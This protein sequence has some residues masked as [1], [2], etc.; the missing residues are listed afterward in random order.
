MTEAEV[1]DQIAQGLVYGEYSLLLG[2]GAS[3]GAVGGNGRALPTGAGL[4]DALIEQFN[5]DTGGETL[6]LSQVYDYLQQVGLVGQA[7]TFL[8]DW[9]VD[10][11]P[12][13]QHLLAE[14]NWK[15]IWTLNIDD[16]IEKAFRETGRS[17]ESLTWNQR[18]SDRISPSSQ[19]IIH[20]HGLAG[21]LPADDTKNDALVFS[22]SD[23]AREVANP[24]TWHKVFFD[25]F[26]GDSFL[27][28]G[29]QLTQEIDLID[30]LNPGNA[31]RMTTGFPSVV[32]VPE[33][34]QI[35]RTQ[36][37]ASGFT[38][39]E[40]DGERFINRLI[41]HFRAIISE[42][43]SVYG[44]STPGLR[45]FLQQFIDLR[46]YEP[47]DT[48][49]GDFYSG[50]QPTW[51]TVLAG[52]DAI[53]D[54]TSQISDEIIDLAVRDE[55]YQ[56]FVFFTGR[57]GSG[58]S[59]GLLRIASNL[60]A[61]GIFP[62]LFRG[63]EYMDVEATIE[64]LQSVP[65]TVLLFDDFADHSSSTLQR[66]SEQCKEQ[67]IRMLLVGSDRSTKNDIV[68]DR[69]DSQY[70]DA[71]LDNWYGRLTDDDIE[72]I[73]DK[74]HSR[75]R[76]GKI[77]RWQRD[78]QRDYFA[79]YA[80]RSL[81]DALAELEGGSGF[82]ETIE[83][84]YRSLPSNGVRNLYAASCLCYE[85]SIPLPTGIAARVAGITPKD[86]IQQIEN[87]YKGILV[88][89]RSG[90]RPPHRITATMVAN[91]L[92]SA[93]KSDIAF[94][95]AVALSPHIDGMSIRNGTREYRIAR[96]L[97]NHEFVVRTSGEHDG[98]KFYDDL[99]EYYDWNARYWDQRALF[100]SRF[101][102]HETARSYAERSV[103]VHSHP[104]GYNT[105]GTVLLRM[106]V[107]QGSIDALNDGIDNLARSK[108]FREWGRREH[109]FTAFFT[110]L[111]RFAEVWGIHEVPPSV[112]NAWSVWFREAQSSQAFS[113]HQAHDL[114]ADWQRRWLGFAATD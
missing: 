31:A 114:L 58:K 25:E 42:H 10:C 60:R 73:I 95:L 82:K 62:F 38:I 112:R 113:T 109:P 85:Q 105:L 81:F 67:N 2:A 9:F 110:S 79:G 51:N 6:P 11:R 71:N 101:D 30:A 61:K 107:R 26:A 33:I 7:N 40:S 22:L 34:T 97:M 92:P 56:K 23:Y 77:T 18:F 93:V 106:A 64:W 90:I 78:R 91:A 24:R 87:E 8:R 55:I 75:G 20:L 99:R 47:T 14:F 80:S 76:L 57:P 32:V 72:R 94:A 41:E 45:R 48:N 39:V 66:L 28:I 21:R 108:N 52:D 27:V 44:P 70:L 53:L 83:Q 111:I 96:N 54:K 104:F 46:T 36:L 17:I 88:M 84:L 49:A 16:V 50:Y 15:R 3:V 89:S 86:L 63:D 35:R 1:I 29:A 4:R 103:Q 102:N 59:T 37:E 68:H 65:R 98:R 74:L 12:S 19:Q 100:E 43:D 5:I 13:W 69:I